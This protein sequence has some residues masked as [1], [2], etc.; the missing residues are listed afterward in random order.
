[1]DAT[2][3]PRLTLTKDD[4]AAPVW[5]R[6]EAYLNGR[7]QH[8]RETNDGMKA[9]PDRCQHVGRIAEVK[10]LLSLAE[11]QAPNFPGLNMS[12]PGFSGTAR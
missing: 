10:F 2:T 9:E 8:L 7:L 4:K 11:E 6:I 5:K 1:M 12:R 3:P